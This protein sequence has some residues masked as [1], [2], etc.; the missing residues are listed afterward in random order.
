VVIDVPALIPWEDRWIPEPNTG[1]FLWQGAR[2]NKGYGMLGRGDKTFTAHRYA[3]MMEHGPIPAGMCVL[4]RCDTR[5][6][7]NPEHLFLGTPRDNTADMLAKGRGSVVFGDG[8]VKSRLRDCEVAEMRRLY[9]AGVRQG[10]LARMFKT[11]NQNV[12]DIVR[13]KSRKKAWA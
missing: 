11:T 13:G 8:F 7:V 1:C 10:I 3:W 9:A 6:C 5:T 2:N 12:S 4:H